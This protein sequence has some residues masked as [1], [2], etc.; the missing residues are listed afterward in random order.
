MTHYLEA[1]HLDLGVFLTEASILYGMFQ[2]FAW[3]VLFMHLFQ[4]QGPSSAE[5]SAIKWVTVLCLKVRSLSFFEVHLVSFGLYCVENCLI[6][7]HK[8]MSLYIYINLYTECKITSAFRAYGYFYLSCLFY[9]C[10][11]FRNQN[12]CLPGCCL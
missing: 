4:W 3:F 5:K 7:L 1:E 11:T 8:I 2:L 6:I 9:L 10:F 12:A